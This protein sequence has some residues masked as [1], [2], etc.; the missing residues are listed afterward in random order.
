[1]VRPQAGHVGMVAGSGAKARLWEALLA[2]MR[3]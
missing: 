2:W 3:A 1:V